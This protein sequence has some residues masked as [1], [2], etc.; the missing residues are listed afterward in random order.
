MS[1]VAVARSRRASDTCGVTD[2]PDMRARYEHALAEVAEMKRALAERARHVA[3]L[4][5]R[6]MHQVEEGARRESRRTRRPGDPSQPRATS[7]APSRPPRRR[8]PSRRRSG[9][10]STSASA[11]SAGSSASSP[12]F[13]SSSR[14]SGA[15]VQAP[16][17]RL[18]SRTSRGRRSRSPRPSRRP[19]RRCRS[20]RP[21]PS[22][23][24][25]RPRAGERPGADSPK[26]RATR[27]AISLVSSEQAV[28][29]R[30]RGSSRRPFHAC[31]RM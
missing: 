9:S 5:Q 31:L 8:K 20:S 26:T 19:R 14:R 22:S 11:T 23:T 24:P 6:L 13:A 12:A 28:P 4:E 30:V 21:S 29:R 7:L 2:L 15:A 27:P 3:E 18:H 10:G 16:L 17:P 1:A 25:R